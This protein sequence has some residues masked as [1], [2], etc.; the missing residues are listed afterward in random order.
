MAK[1]T[2][3]DQQNGLEHRWIIQII[4]EIKPSDIH[5]DWMTVADG[6]N[7]GTSVT[8]LAYFVADGPELGTSCDTRTAY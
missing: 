6:P 2:I 7:D 3:L 4:P 1:R 8:F 5:I